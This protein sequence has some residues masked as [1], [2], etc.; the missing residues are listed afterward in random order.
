[1][2]R[3]RLKDIQTADTSE[4]NVNE[5]FVHWL[6]TKGPN[7]LLIVMIVISGLLWWNSYKTGQERYRA[8]AWNAFAE[9]SVSGLPASFEDVAQTH[10]DVDALHELGLLSAAD[11]YLTAVINNTTLGS[12]DDITSS[13]SAEDRTFYLD[14][15]DTLYSKLIASDDN[16]D[17]VTLF[18]VSGLFG[19]A[20]IA[21]SKG[22]IESANGFYEAILTRADNLFPGLSSQAEFRMKTIAVLANEVVLPTDAEVTARNNQVEQRDPTPVNSSID[23]LTDLTEPG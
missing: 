3:D 11:A 8:E 13:L 22:D 19:R 21:E 12:N 5:D 7:Y 18:V 17:A 15:A 20:A 10:T 16:S 2:D 23:A 6:K 14:K 1:M 9:A 4:S